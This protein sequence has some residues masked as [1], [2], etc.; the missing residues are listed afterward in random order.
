MDRHAW[1][2]LGFAVIAAAVFL[3]IGALNA[4]Y[5]SQESTTIE[6][7]TLPV[8]EMLRE[9][10][11]RLPFPPGYFLVLNGWTELFGESEVAVRSLSLLMAL[12][13]AVVLLGWLRRYYGGWTA[14]MTV[15]M[16]GL[17]TFHIRASTE[18][19]PYAM[20]SLWVTIWLWLYYRFLRDS[21]ASHKTIFPLGI[22]QT[23]LIATDYISAILLAV[24]AIHFFLFD[25]R[26]PA[27]TRRFAFS[28]SG[29]L[30]ASAAWFPIFLANV[31]SPLAL[32]GGSERG[33]MKWLFLA[34]S[35]APVHV[36][37]LVAWGSGAVCLGLAAYTVLG[38]WRRPSE[39]SANQLARGPIPLPLWRGA[40]A[41]GLTVL[42]LAAP[43]LCYVVAPWSAEFRDAL[44]GQ[45]LR[46]VALAGIFHFSMLFLI[47]I[48]ANRVT[49]SKDVRIESLVVGVVVVWLTG[50][51]GLGAHHDVMR[52]VFILPLMILLVVRSY[53]PQRISTGV[54]ILALVVATMT[55][56]IL[57]SPDHFRP[58]PDLRAVANAIRLAPGRESDSRTFVL[59]MFEQRGLEHY[60]GAGTTS[61]LMAVEHMGGASTLSRRVNLVLAGGEPSEWEGQV[62]AAARHL[63]PSYRQT[64]V[65]SAENVLMVTF[66]RL[67]PGM[68]R[69]D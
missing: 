9:V 16:V 44:D 39:Q 36:S 10:G 62:T 26:T 17:S 27:Q 25:R 24:S 38:E 47:F 22:V 14:A 49:R 58:R 29:V 6:V 56:S 54:A 7:I 53:E 18:A 48:N 60:L 50:T 61:G 20:F 11:E 32:M 69:V 15:L 2:L 4:P 28:L 55:P 31:Q 59:P 64:G 5:S 57:R 30:V 12:L 21:E 68:R 51:I 67:P 8:S 23:L 3:R 35:P 66:E 42:S 13:S 1:K 34:F 52:L 41:T 63:G 65:R 33:D 40:L 37:G 43:T 45:M 19:M 46:A